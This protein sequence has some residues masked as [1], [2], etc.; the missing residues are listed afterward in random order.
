MGKVSPKAG[1]SALA[2]QDSTRV[3]AR[4]SMVGGVALVLALRLSHR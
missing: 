1:G 3:R 4:W 2:I